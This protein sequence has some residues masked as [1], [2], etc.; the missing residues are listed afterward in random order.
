MRIGPILKGMLHD[1][2]VETNV[3]SKC[4]TDRSWASFGVL[5]TKA[6]KV[7]ANDRQLE[8]QRLFHFPF[9]KLD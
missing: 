4:V 8:G 2:S 6:I 5:L 3:D 9:Y 1:S 7:D